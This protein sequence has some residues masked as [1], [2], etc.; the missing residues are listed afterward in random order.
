MYSFVDSE[1]LCGCEV[2]AVTAHVGGMC[3]GSVI[4]IISTQCRHPALDT[5]TEFRHS[6]SEVQLTGV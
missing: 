5:L 2:A 4:I 6:R 3:D 1:A